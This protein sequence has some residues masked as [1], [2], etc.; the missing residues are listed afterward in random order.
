MAAGVNFQLS[1]QLYYSL[2]YSSQA[3]PCVT[4]GMR[5]GHALAFVFH[6]DT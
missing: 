1:S 3:H 5:G 6:F 4:E 2:S